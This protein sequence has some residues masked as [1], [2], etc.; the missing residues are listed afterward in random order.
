M[1]GLL[2]MLVATTSLKAQI[3]QLDPSKMQEISVVLEN[4]RAEIKERGLDEQEVVARMKLRGVDL[5]NIDPL[6]ADPTQIQAVFND[7]IAELEREE[8]S[9]SSV[10][11]SQSPTA[12]VVDTTTSTINV[13]DI[14]TQ[15]I[16]EELGEAKL[17][18]HHIFRNGSLR[19]NRDF[20]KVKAPE[21]YR[22]GA[23]DQV[24]ISIFGT[25]NAT[26]KLI[27]AE[28][29][30]L[31]P[32]GVRPIYLKGVPLSQARRI[33]TSAF[34]QRYRFNDNQIEIGLDLAR[35]INVNIVG[36]VLLPADY[37]LPATNNIVNALTQAGGPTNI[38]SVRQIE[39]IKGDE[40]LLFDLYA[41]LLNPAEANEFS[42]E[43]GDFINVPVLQKVVTINGAVRRPFRYELLEGENL[44]RLIE[45]AAG[46]EPNAYI[47]NINVRRIDTE[48]EALQILD[49]NW[50][51]LQAQGL[52]FE[53]Q[54]NDVVTIR[55]I[56][57]RYQN[58]VEIIGNGAVEFPGEYQLQEGMRISDLVQKARLEKE[59]RTDVVF[60][61]RVQADGTT[62]YE[63]INL[64]EVLQNP[65]G[66]ADLILQAEDRLR[67]TQQSEFTDVGFVSV[68]GAVRKDST[69]VELGFNDELRV[70]D[71]LF[72]SGG[73]QP[74]ANAYAFLTRQNPNN[75]EERNSRA[76]NVR[77]IVDNP[78]GSA[79]LVLQPFDRI[80][81]FSNQRFTETFNVQVRG[82]VRSP[83]SYTY[84]ENLTLRELIQRSGGLK[85]GAATNK[86]EVFRIQFEENEAT[87]TI[88]AVLEVD[89]DM[90]V[91]NDDF[92]LQPLDIVVV[93]RVP[94]FDLIQTVEIIGEVQYPGDYPLID[95]NERIRSIIERAGGLTVE[96]FAEGATLY[97]NLDTI[98][99]VVFDFEK[100]MTSKGSIDNLI[101][102]SGDVIRVPKQQDLVAI[103]GATKAVELLPG[104]Y[105]QDDEIDV[106]FNE[107]KRAMYY[108]KEYAGG[109]S[110][111]ARKSGI[112][113]RQFNGE[114]DR[115]INF[116][117][118]KI[119]P[120]VKKGGAITIP[121]KPQDEIAESEPIETEPID[122]GEIV[123]NTIAQ[124]TAVFTLIFLI[125]S[126]TN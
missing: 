41:Y 79:D 62:D 72:L 122:W 43:E 22:L 75:S 36:E 19:I 7:V 50:R 74:N 114:L 116:G 106:V 68:F 95:Q 52:D 121:Y 108:I 2:L 120:K 65:G 67:I 60:L 104:T 21:S 9:N 17:Y 40:R 94:D 16:D 117:L 85:L 90:R 92:L 81:V 49:V 58:Y 33:I 55:S 20:S 42:L 99:Y 112:A 47:S 78:G 119:Y 3:T 84:T 34:Q 45:Y 70:S 59:A 11:P 4:A 77:D 125:E 30:F 13:E 123:S 83:G 69:I 118:F 54:S 76:I 86:V 37:N 87:Q 18:G 110:Q 38:G 56:E 115:T 73:L 107:G 1:G 8:Q 61:T 82:A 53:L 15:K 23:G 71:A 46:L 98:G 89:E 29:G 66:S 88:V 31:R 39:L 24:A 100:A 35:T 48:N 97:R 12:I 96:A 10:E 27:V 26:F 63:R 91:N 64:Q 126:R 103:S 124:L 28:D 109:V 101:L 93:R 80:E 51:A 111:D 25:S 14:V 6:T 57:K 113:V 5:E 32:V 105:L 102:K 44:S